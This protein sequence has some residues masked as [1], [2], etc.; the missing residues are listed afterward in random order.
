MGLIDGKTLGRTFLWGYAVLISLVFC[1]FINPSRCNYPK[2][3]NGQGPL[4]LLWYYDPDCY[5]LVQ[6]C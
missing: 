6:N 3:L 5:G 4:V 2:F 1:S